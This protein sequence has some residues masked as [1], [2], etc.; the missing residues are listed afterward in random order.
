VPESSITYRYGRWTD[1]WQ[2]MRE[3]SSGRGVERLSPPSPGSWP[4]AANQSVRHIGAALRADLRRLRWGGSP[5]GYLASFLISMSAPKSNFHLNRVTKWA[6]GPSRESVFAPSLRPS[7]F[8]NPRSGAVLHQFPATPKAIKGMDPG[9]SDARC[10]LQ[11]AF[12]VPIPSFPVMTMIWDFAN[13]RDR[14]ART[15][16]SAAVMIVPSSVNPGPHASVVGTPAAWLSLDSRQRRRRRRSIGTNTIAN[17]S[18]HGLASIRSAPWRV[19][20]RNSSKRHLGTTSTRPERRRSVSAG[21]SSNPLI[22]LER[23]RHHKQDHDGGDSARGY[24][25]KRQR[26]ASDSCMSTKTV[27]LASP[28]R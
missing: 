14:Y 13:A 11:D 2:A 10:G 15:S 24:W 23:A 6:V 1:A 3:H 19:Y 5:P 22:A 25:S 18:K 9:T 4:H 8:G 20:W 16:R 26:E 21:F 28:A 7:R 12:C 27:C 17:S